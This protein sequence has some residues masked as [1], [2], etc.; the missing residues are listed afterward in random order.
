MATH[1]KKY[2]FPRKSL[3]HHQIIKFLV[4]CALIME[5]MTWIKVARAP[6]VALSL[7]RRAIVA[8]IPP[9]DN[10]TTP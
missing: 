4:E 5:G 10:D 1:A 9:R 7:P 6:T 8:A 3:S 2:V